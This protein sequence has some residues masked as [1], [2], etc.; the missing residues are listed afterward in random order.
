MAPFERVAAMH[1]TTVHEAHTPA[2]GP[3]PI[4]DI[5]AELPRLA[6]M[7]SSGKQSET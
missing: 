2:A 1:S 4:T 3:L 7:H 5:V 6:A